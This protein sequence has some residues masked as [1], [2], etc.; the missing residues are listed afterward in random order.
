MGR[1][2]AV[3]QHDVTKA[4]SYLPIAETAGCAGKESLFPKSPTSA[5]IALLQA[6]RGNGNYRS[7]CYTDDDLFVEAD[8]ADFEGGSGGGS[9]GNSTP[10]A[11]STLIGHYQA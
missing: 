9:G 3:I 8:K 10:T 1:K 5:Q 11:N 7:I 6:T 4:I 2:V